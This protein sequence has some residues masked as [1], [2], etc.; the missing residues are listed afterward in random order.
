MLSTSS[1]D[2]KRGEDVRARLAVLSEL[3]DD[4]TRHVQIWSRILRARR[5]DVEGTAPPDRDDEYLFYQNL[6]GA[7]PAE[8]T[9]YA[10]ADPAAL[11]S[12]VERMKA[13]VTKSIREARVKSTWA[14]P[15]LEYENAALGFV[16]ESLDPERSQAFFAAF[17]PFQ[18]RVATLGVRNS[19]AQTVLKLTAPG[20]PD[21]Y[22]GANLWDLSMVDPD[23]RRPVDYA[24]RIA[25]LGEVENLSEI[26]TAGE[27]RA[28]KMRRLLADWRDG[29]IKLAI[30]RA[31]LHFRRDN[32]E[33]FSSGSY[34]PLTVSGSK[35]SHICCFARSI[36]DRTI[37]VAVTRLP[38]ALSLDPDW[39]DTAIAVPEEFRTRK[40][41]DILTGEKVGV[42]ELGFDPRSVFG[43]LPVA[44]L[45][46]E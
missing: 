36:S 38:A 34:E 44:V 29:A 46:A 7:W 37:V 26:E 20:V 16:E 42:G 10:M 4:W 23:N 22:Q 33:L 28:V 5:G 19:L 21:I 45:A 6:I 41:T 31:I 12:F 27:S 35:S 3:A 43:V 30:I 8:L 18:E 1:H 13:V 17:L 32:P 39:G 25:M 14:M 40:W 2:T 11:Q 24:R 15:N 9:G